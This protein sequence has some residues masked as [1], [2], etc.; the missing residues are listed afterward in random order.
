MSVI[1]DSSA[2][3]TEE[4]AEELHLI[5]RDEMETEDD[6]C[7]CERDPIQI[8]SMCGHCYA[9]GEIKTWQLLQTK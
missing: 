5:A 2:V 8:G 9:E 3:L 4:E 7:S 1:I 6:T